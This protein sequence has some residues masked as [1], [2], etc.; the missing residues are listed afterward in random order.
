MTAIFLDTN[1]LLYSISD[2]PLEGRKRTIA[3]KL[4]DRTDVGLSVQVLQEFYVQAT[5]ASR[6][7]PLSHAIA[8][9]LIGKWA[10]FPMQSMTMDIL[11]SALAIKQRHNLS[12]WDSAIVAAALALQCQELYTEDMRDGLTINGPRL[13]NPFP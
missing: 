3:L 2:E 5:R 7:K 11:T 13:V 12:Y 8:S 6:A 10:R 9:G 4:I 1:I